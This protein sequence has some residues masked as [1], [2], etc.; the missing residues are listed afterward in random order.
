MKDWIKMEYGKV[1]DEES[2]KREKIIRGYWSERV[3]KY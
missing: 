1:S 2:K 3:D